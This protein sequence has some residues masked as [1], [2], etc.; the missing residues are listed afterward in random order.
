M[1][2]DS[3]WQSSSNVST[4]LRIAC[5]EV[6]DASKYSLFC[7]FHMDHATKAHV[8]SSFQD[9]LSFNVWAK[10]KKVLAKESHFCNFPR[11]SAHTLCANGHCQRM[12]K[13]I[14]SLEPHTAHLG[15]MGTLRRAKFARVGRMSKLAHHTNFHTFGGMDKFHSPF[16]MRLSSCTSKCSTLPI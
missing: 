3:L 9:N 11:T 8:S 12:W 14:S 5:G 1:L 16:Q 10:Q 4:L 7:M 15:S 2:R 6:W 13:A